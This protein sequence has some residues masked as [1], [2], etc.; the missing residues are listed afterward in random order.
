MF[1]KSFQVWKPEREHIPNKSLILRK[2]HEYGLYFP[3][4]LCHFDLRLLEEMFNGVNR[5]WPV[6]SFSENCI[7]GSG[8]Q[9]SPVTIK[10]SNTV[11]FS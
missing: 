9:N 4:S 1:K 2:I 10:S 11:Y 3:C 6:K 5:A 7:Q 8:A